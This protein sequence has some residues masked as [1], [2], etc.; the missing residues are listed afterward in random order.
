MAI[1]LDDSAGRR[2]RRERER[3]LM[4][5]PDFIDE[6]CDDIASTTHT[7]VD[8]S[9]KYDIRY[10][11]LH[12]WIHGDVDRTQKYAKALEARNGSLQDRVLRALIRVA[13]FDIRE[14][15]TEDGAI[16]SIK[17]LP[18]HV[19]KVIG[20]IDLDSELDKEGRVVSYVKRVRVADRMRGIENIGR[21]VEM[22]TDKVKTEGPLMVTVKRFG[23]ESADKPSE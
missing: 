7:L 13:E 22:F 14:L 19:A 6:V 5:E 1:K 15:Y 21:H 23:R 9:E 12:Q 8:I 2:A 4:A 16:K 20:A 10:H 18:E 11:E 3:S 17:D